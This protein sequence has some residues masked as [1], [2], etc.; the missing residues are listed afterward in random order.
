M[1]PSP[2]EQG[3]LFYKLLKMGRDKAHLQTDLNR[4]FCTFTLYKFGVWTEVT[5]RH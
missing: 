5:L 4:G 3:E 2:R 1:C